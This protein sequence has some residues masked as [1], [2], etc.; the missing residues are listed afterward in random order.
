MDSYTV[1]QDEF[2][3]WQ[4]LMDGK[5]VSWHPTLARA[6]EKLAWIAAAEESAEG[7]CET[8]EDALNADGECEGCARDEAA[9]N[10]YRRAER[11]SAG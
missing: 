7:S 6:A 10:R 2:G 4:L 1:R 9:R 5:H 8:C 3:D 11:G